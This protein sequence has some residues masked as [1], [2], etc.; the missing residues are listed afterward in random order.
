MPG[1]AQLE[2]VEERRQQ[3][4]SWDLASAPPHIRGEWA[5]LT[6][7]RNALVLAELE[8]D[9]VST[10]PASKQRQVEAYTACSVRDQDDSS[11]RRPVSPTQVCTAN[12]ARVR[13]WR[14]RVY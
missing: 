7:A 14:W 10:Q 13:R 6:E 12:A 3:M 11:E 5:A 2:L 1:V 9:G 8:R 4:L